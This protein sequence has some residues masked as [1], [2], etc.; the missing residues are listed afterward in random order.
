MADKTIG[1]LP[2]ASSLNDDSLLVVEQQSEARSIQGRLIRSFAE[3]VAD[4][5]VS[6]AETAA[7]S[8]EQ[9]AKEAAESFASIGTAV[10]DAQG[11]A[12]EAGASAEQAEQALSSV[13][14]AKN[15]AE[16]AAAT[17]TTK[18]E[19]AAQSAQEAK[20]AASTAAQDAVDEANT[21]LQGYVDA[22]ESAKDAAQASQTAAASSES[23][24]QQSATAAAESQL[25]AEAAAS[26]AA[27]DTTELLQ[28]YVDEANSA[29]EAAK[30]SET[31][32]QTSAAAA[33][34][35]QTAAASSAEE[36]AASADTAHEYSGNPPIIKENRWWTWD[37]GA[38]NYTDTGKKAV[39]NYDKT[40]PSID[41]MEADRGNQPENTMA[42]ITSGVEDD[43]NAK[44]YIMDADGEWRY[45]ADLS[46]LTGVGI[47]S[48]EKTSGTGLPGTE[49]T[50][51]V[52]WTD[53]RSFAYNVYNGRNGEGAGDTSGIAFDIKL[54]ADGWADGTQTVSDARFLS[55]ERYN[56]IVG[57][58]SE[59][60]LDY[61]EC[62]VRAEDVTT[63]GSI[64]FHSD[65]DPDVELTVHILRLEVPGDGSGI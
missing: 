26:K 27:S 57:P 12:Q 32:A 10:E 1:E 21:L 20:D 64:T 56:Y 53:G 39:L 11:Y 59:S 58:A 29:K 62:V 18:A 40:Y 15:D 30:N 22:A 6:R 52:T 37:A 31:A 38:Q 8:A 36:A 49:D 48:W 19:D 60:Y 43:D 24:A 61:V 65:D 4:K 54:L 42:V 17:A 33:L 5:F 63:D 28:G 47:E 25:A 23:S 45:L 41:E 16:A 55:A 44:L 51:T 9:S 2:V 14:Q 34:D 35:S 46:G 50:Y 3:S 7:E 13:T